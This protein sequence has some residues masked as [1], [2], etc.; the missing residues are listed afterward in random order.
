MRE[1][2]AKELRPL[3]SA[4]SELRSFKGLRSASTNR[5]FGPSMRP[6]QFLKRCSERIWLQAPSD[7]SG[8]ARSFAPAP[9]SRSRSPQALRLRLC[10]TGSVS[11]GLLSSPAL[12]RSYSLIGPRS[13]DAQVR[14]VQEAANLEHR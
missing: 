13:R 9:W 7:A 11:F 2:L 4:D 1:R 12:G 3:I 8:I 5:A 6:Q 10:T 14:I